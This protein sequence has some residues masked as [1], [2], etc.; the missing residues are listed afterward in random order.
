MA[1]TL[2]ELADVIVEESL[3][4]ESAEAQDKGC[5]RRFIDFGTTPRGAD[6]GVVET[7]WTAYAVDGRCGPKD[8]RVWFAAPHESV[9]DEPDL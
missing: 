4:I 5:G 7:E 8:Y 6:W 1:R 9:T 2:E 3:T